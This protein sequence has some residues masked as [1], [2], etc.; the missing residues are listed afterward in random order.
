MVTARRD[1]RFLCWAG[2]D[3][4]FLI[5]ANC[6]FGVEGYDAHTLSNH[7]ADLSLGPGLLPGLPNYS[8]NDF[9][10]VFHLMEQFRPSPF[11]LLSLLVRGQALADH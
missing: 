5:W 1:G 3:S 11:L 6:A 7:S 8:R 10:R 4:A 9:D 2:E